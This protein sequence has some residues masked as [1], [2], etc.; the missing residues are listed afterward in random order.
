MYLAI[1]TLLDSKAVAMGG[2]FAM[3]APAKDANATGGVID[4]T[5]PK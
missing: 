3:A 4:D 5:T 1:P 2:D